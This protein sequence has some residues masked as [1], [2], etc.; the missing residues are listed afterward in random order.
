MPRFLAVDWDGSEV[1]FVLV[2]QN[3]DKLSVL[4]VGS[5]PIETPEETTNND[6]ETPKRDIGA[7]LQRALKSNRIVGGINL[8]ALSSSYADVMYFTL[9]PAKAD[10]IP[11]LLKNQ[12]VRELPNFLEPQPIDYISLN[13]VPTEQ[14]HVLAVSLNRVQSKAIQAIGRAAH[15]KPAKIEYRPAAAAALL[16][17]GGVLEQDAPPLLL[18]NLLADE[19]DLI[20]IVENKIVYVRSVKIP[21]NL[22]SDDSTE[23]IFSEITRTIAVGLQDVSDEQIG[24]VYIFAGEGELSELVEKLNNL[25]LEVHCVD[26][27]SLAQVRTKNLPPYPGRYAALLGMVICEAVGKKPEIDLLHPKSKPQPPS[28]ARYA[29]LMFLLLGV[30]LWGLHSWNQR[31]LKNLRT[32]RDT[33]RKEYDKLR[34]D[35]ANV[36]PQYTVL[37][38]ASVLDT[39]DAVWLDTIRDIIDLFPGQEDMVVNQMRFISGPIPN[40]PYSAYYSGRIEIRAVVRD[41]SVLPTLKMKLEAKQL[42]RLVPQTPV[43]NSVGGGFPWTHNFTIRCLKQSNPANYLLSQPEEIK[44]ES[45][46]QPEVYQ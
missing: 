26:P 6:T 25:S 12:A 46:K 5:E 44:L 3:K 18:V 8:Y 23:R 40:D 19:L 16:I 13:H 17:N 11:E 15:R 1:R 38:N 21:E 27:L 29:L 22:K 41:L 36:L 24:S 10:E 42:Y 43:Q 34:T 14:R 9:P 33:L 31:T 37:S 7:T 28:Y 2:N 35:Y 39:Q 32:K 20:V 4:Q 30:V 45:Q